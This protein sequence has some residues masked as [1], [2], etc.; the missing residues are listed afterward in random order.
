MLD[1]LAD[2]DCGRREDLATIEGRFIVD[3]RLWLDFL[4]QP[5]V[6]LF[7]SPVTVVGCV[8]LECGRAFDEVMSRTKNKTADTGRTS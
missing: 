8:V 4:F 6:W 7:D 5:N 2:I 1:P 3:L